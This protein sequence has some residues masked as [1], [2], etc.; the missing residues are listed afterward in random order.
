VNFYAKLLKMRV[1][2]HSRRQFLFPPG[3]EEIN[4]V[5][6]GGGLILKDI[7]GQLFPAP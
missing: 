6:V 7:V 4:R 5:L 3:H 1:K 2:R